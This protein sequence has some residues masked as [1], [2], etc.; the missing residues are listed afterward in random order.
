MNKNDKNNKLT[1]RA[2]KK[3]T[4]EDLK[5]VIGGLGD[6]VEDTVEGDTVEDPNGAKATGKP[7]KAS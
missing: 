2:P 1:D 4:V 7:A 5:R 3:L 6:L